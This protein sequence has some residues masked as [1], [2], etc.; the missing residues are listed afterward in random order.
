MESNIN[1]ILKNWDVEK[2]ECTKKKSTIWQIDEEYILKI[3]DNKDKIERNVKILLA[4]NSLQIPVSPIIHTKNNESY[5][6]HQNLYYLLM[7][8]LDGNCI[9]E[10][11][12]EKTGFK[13][14]S[15]IGRLHI[16]LKKC[17]DILHFEEKDLL[18]DLE[19]WVSENF[20]RNRWQLFDREE[21]SNFIL[22]LKT[23]YNELPRQLIHRDVH[24]GNFLFLN[25]KFSG[26]I[27]FDLS[28]RNIRIFDLCYF[29]TSIF[30]EDA[31]KDITDDEWLIFLNET[32]L[33]YETQI[34][35]T[36]KEKFSLPFIMEAIEILCASYFFGINNEKFTNDALKNYNRIKNLEDS[37]LK[38]LKIN[39]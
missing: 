10:I 33:G 35:L 15:I 1:E 17:E 6:T 9:S 27:D 18:K 36:Q 23:F 39:I 11:K 28:Q 7:K 4:L 8:K 5:A 14:G 29:L 20:E 34:K 21:Y 31:G 19:G 37:I 24:L 25:E 13:I 26:Y 16:A 22:K 12:N 38:E 3:Y 2:N 32:V 30:T